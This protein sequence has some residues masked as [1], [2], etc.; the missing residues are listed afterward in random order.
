V[1]DENGRDV[2]EDGQTIGEI[3]A[4]GNNVMLGYYLDATT[5][6]ATT[7]D[8]WMR[9]GDLAI[10]HPDGYLKIRDQVID[11]II[12]GG[13]NIASIEV[14]Q[15]IVAHPDAL[16]A[17]VVAAPDEKWG[18]VPVAYVT[19]REGATVR[20]DDIR[21]LV[22]SRLA[23]TESTQPQSA[24]TTNK[25]QPQPMRPDQTPPQRQTPHLQPPQLPG[26]A[27]PVDIGT[28]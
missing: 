6:A 5:T 13:E 1:L 20:E 12:S 11:V 26:L 21:V 14:E 16:E 24:P 27:D 4:H 19:L 15:A 17:A 28:A 23:E 25:S 22:R 9:T 10:R 8:G 2:P 18:Q 7:A 3:V